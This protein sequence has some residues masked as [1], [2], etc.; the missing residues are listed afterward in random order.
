[1]KTLVIIH[2]SL[3]E[4]SQNSTTSLNRAVNHVGTRSMS[5]IEN[6]WYKDNKNNTFKHFPH[7]MTLLICKLDMY[8]SSGLSWSIYC[9]TLPLSHGNKTVDFWF[10]PNHN[11]DKSNLESRHKFFISLFP[12][13]SQRP[14]SKINFI[15][16]ADWKI[17]YDINLSCSF[18]GHLLWVEWP[19]LPMRD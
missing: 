7:G 8:V 16:N 9:Q 13:S 5:I 1:M 2:F 3:H 12:I 17:P 6:C 14:R 11:F 10:A 19:K 15:F 18:H 4:F